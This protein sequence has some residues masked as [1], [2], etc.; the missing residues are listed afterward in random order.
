M[1][2][3]NRPTSD[4]KKVM[5]GLMISIGIILFLTSLHIMTINVTGDTQ[6]VLRTTFT[7]ALRITIGLTTI[8][9]IFIL[10]HFIKAMVYVATTPKWLREEQG[11]KKE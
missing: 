7:V 8:A 9:F 5:A 2:V 3:V 10:I 11:G 4:I 6:S 1:K